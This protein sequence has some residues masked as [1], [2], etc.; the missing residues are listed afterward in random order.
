M[1]F[2]Q[3]ALPPADRRDIQTPTMTASQEQIWEHDA[4]P[5]YLAD[6][7]RAQQTFIAVAD[8]EE[9]RRFG[10]LTWETLANILEH[11]CKAG[12]RQ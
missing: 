10:F 11:F 6:F 9:A 5:D 1:S 3:S 2:T 12:P 8:E 4:L 7:Y